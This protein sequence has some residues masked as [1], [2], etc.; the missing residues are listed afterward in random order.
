MFSD[1]L[2][3]SRASTATYVDLVSGLVTEAAVDQP[4]FDKN[5]ILIERTATNLLANSEYNNSV[6]TPSSNA[7]TAQTMNFRSDITSNAILL[8]GSATGYAYR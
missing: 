1:I 3:H 4:R 6:Y 2:T 8:D 5:G 7:T